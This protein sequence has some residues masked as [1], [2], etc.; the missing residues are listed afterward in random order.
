M[1]VETKGVPSKLTVNHVQT[2]CSTQLQQLVPAFV[3]SFI[4]V[5]PVGVRREGNAHLAR[6]M[7]VSLWSNIIWFYTSPGIKV[8]TDQ[9]TSLGL[10]VTDLI[11][12]NRETVFIVIRG[13][14]WG[15]ICCTHE[16]IF[17]V[18]TTSLFILI[19]IENSPILINCIERTRFALY[20]ISIPPESLPWVTPL[21]LEAGNTISLQPEG[22][23]VG[24]SPLLQ[25]SRKTNTVSRPLF[26]E[27]QSGAAADRRRDFRLNT[28]THAHTLKHKH[29]N[30]IT[31]KCV[32]Q[33]TVAF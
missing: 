2:Q 11:F 31:R 19:Q 28:H 29:K 22:Q 25:V 6:Y 27:R 14:G 5:V 33:I 13:F 9:Y 15:N 32:H 30:R 16:Y 20:K 21:S 18:A 7:F 24:M 3:D 17:I 23:P 10:V 26:C 1:C 12:Q 4:K 8:P